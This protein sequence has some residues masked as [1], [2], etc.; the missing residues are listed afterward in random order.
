MSNRLAMD[1]AA[2]LVVEAYN[3]CVSADNPIEVHEKG[4]RDLVT[5]LDYAIENYIVNSIVRDFP[6]DKIVA[7][8]NYASEL[9]AAR[10]WVIDPIDGTVNF[11]RKLPLYGVQI[12]LVENKQTIASAIYFPG[13]KELYTAYREGGSYRDGQPIH[14][15]QFTSPARSILSMGDFTKKMGMEEENA[16]RLLGLG[17]LVND[18]LK[19]KM[20][21]AACY[22][23]IALAQG[24]TDVHMM[25]SFGIWDVMPGILLV[26][27]AGGICLTMTG[28]KFAPE[29]KTLVCGCHEDLVRFVVERLR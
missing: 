3:V 16:R 6:N 12:A 19:V 2:G 18:V 26:E 4:K 24:Y 20:F 8:E 7:E 13:F 9:T 29:A 23:F 5:T 14:V 25:F 22:D 27:E 21:G 17:A 11:T 15:N 10:T 28:E 1:Y